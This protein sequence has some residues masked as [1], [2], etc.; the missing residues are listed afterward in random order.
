L[1]TKYKKKKIG[2]N[3]YKLKKNGEKM[4]NPDDLMNFF[5]KDLDED[6]LKSLIE[7]LFWQKDDKFPENPPNFAFHMNEEQSIFVFFDG[8][9]I[10]AEWMKNTEDFPEFEENQKVF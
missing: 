2:Y 9:W 6:F 4:K 5:K 1:E 7:Y 8:K 10:E 3:L